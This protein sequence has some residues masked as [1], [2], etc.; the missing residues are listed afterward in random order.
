MAEV[1]TT[2]TIDP[3]VPCAVDHVAF[4][5]AETGGTVRYAERLKTP[6]S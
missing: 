2:L 3:E 5:L 6:P 4:A 1:R